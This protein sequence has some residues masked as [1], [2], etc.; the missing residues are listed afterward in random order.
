MTRT[1]ADAAALLSVLAGADRRDPAA[2]SDQI[3]VEK[4]YTKFLNPNGLK[5]ARIGVVRKYAGFSIEVDRLFDE[6]IAAIKH[7][8]AEVIDPV[9][10]PTIGKFDD[11][12]LQV[13][14]F[15]FKDDL[16]HYLAWLG[17]NTQVHNIK[18]VIEFN[19]SHR[20][21]EMPYFGQD[22]I[23][24]AEA[25]GPLTSPDYQKALQQCR[26]QSRAEGI[27]AALAKH[28]L[29][30]LIA[31]TGSPAWTTDLVNGDHTVGGSSTLAAVAGYPNINVPMGFVFGL[32]V[33]IS[34]FGRAWSEGKLIQLAY[35]YEQLTKA[36]KT[37]AFLT[38]ANLKASS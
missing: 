25:K 10:I 4:D 17:S 24:Q 9:E 22:L 7:A 27:D 21:Q 32:P 20:A 31:P 23:V 5:G 30:A 6:A 15:D 18:E 33:G 26:Q 29:D 35:A 8:G 28:K 38:S 11:A 2:A 1:V 37:P 16:N 34:F 19:E 12:E 13:L 36:R 14:L 3:H